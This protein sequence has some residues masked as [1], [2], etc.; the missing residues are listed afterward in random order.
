MKHEKSCGILD[1]VPEGRRETWQIVGNRH[2]LTEQEKKT[3]LN[4]MTSPGRGSIYV[5]DREMGFS[6]SK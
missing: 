3:V 6:G 1:W 4:Y 5:S 2:S